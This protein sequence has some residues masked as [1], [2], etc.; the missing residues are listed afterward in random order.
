MNEIFIDTIHVG[1][2]FT[3]PN[4]KRA[5]KHIRALCDKEGYDIVVTER[6]RLTQNVL[7]SACF[8][9]DGSR[10]HRINEWCFYTFCDM[11]NS[12]IMYKETYR[13]STKSKRRL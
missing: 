13:D 11:L 4:T 9:V 5:Y 8:D 7:I 2:G 6:N 1:A 10:M 12:S 3:I